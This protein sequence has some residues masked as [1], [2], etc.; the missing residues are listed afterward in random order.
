MAKCLH[1]KI[2]GFRPG[3]IGFLPNTMLNQR[4]KPKSCGASKVCHSEGES[5]VF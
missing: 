3:R 5:V 1:K 4:K 2:R